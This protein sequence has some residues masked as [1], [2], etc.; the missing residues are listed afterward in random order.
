MTQK[1]TVG[2]ETEMARVLSRELN[3]QQHVNTATA[4][5]KDGRIRGGGKNTHAARHV[6]RAAKSLDGHQQRD[7]I[8]FNS[9]TLQSAYWSFVKLYLG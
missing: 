6:F 1:N 9:L 2:H 7:T 4:W 8:Y 5:D 3:K